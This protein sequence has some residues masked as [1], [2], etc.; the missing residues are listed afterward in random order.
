MAKVYPDRKVNSGA[1][2]EQSALNQNGVFGSSKYG[3]VFAKSMIR[4]AMLRIES[5]CW[6]LIAPN[7]VYFC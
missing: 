1:A 6:F 2:S 7:L 4:M 3:V 5:M